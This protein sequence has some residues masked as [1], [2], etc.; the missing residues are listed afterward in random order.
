MRSPVEDYVPLLSDNPKSHTPGWL[1]VMADLLSRLNQVSSTEWSLHP[2][3][4]K[5]ICQKWFTPHVD[6]FATRLNH[7]F[8]L[9][10]SQVP[11]QYLGHIRS[12][13]KLDGSDCLC[14]PSHDSPSQGDQK[15][16]AIQLPHH[17]SSPRLARDAL[18]LVPS[19]ALNK[20]PT[21]LTSVNNSSQTVP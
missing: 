3:V 21:S 16:Q 5:Q 17:C 9:C 8:T 20:D 6:L 4:F 19:A 10:I 11:D 15:D 1:N 14:L 7:K 13:H 2:Q 18:V 12:K